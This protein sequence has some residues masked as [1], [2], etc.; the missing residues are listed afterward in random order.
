AAVALARSREGHDRAV[1]RGS[2]ART[3]L[4]RRLDAT[5]HLARGVRP[6]IISLSDITAKAQAQNCHGE[7]ELDDHRSRAF[8]VAVTAFTDT[9]GR[10]SSSPAMT[11]DD[12]SP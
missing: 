2:V 9:S 4:M 11:Q 3:A 10:P 8:S 12:R 6:P 7:S 1:S 5:R